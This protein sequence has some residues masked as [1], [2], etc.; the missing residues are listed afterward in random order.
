VLHLRTC[1]G[2]AGEYQLELDGDG[3]LRASL[4]GMTE[5]GSRIELAGGGGAAF[6]V[7]QPAGVLAAASQTASIA[8]GSVLNS[9]TFTPD[10]AAGGLI[11]VFGS[12]LAR[13]G[14]ET[15]VSVGGRTATVLTALPFQI[16]AQVPFDTPPGSHMLRIDAP[17]GSAGQPFEVRPAA[18]AVF[19]AGARAI[20]VNQSGKLNTPSSPARRGE[21][22]IVYAT[23]L[24]TVSGSGDVRP[25]VIP[26]AAF[27][28]SQEVRV[29]YAGLTPGFVGLYQINLV[30]HTTIPPGIDIPLTLRQGDI[31]SRPVEIS[32]F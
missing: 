28:R 2:S 32:V 4:T 7:T 27:L 16:N 20:V 26:V 6:R 22:V 17:W 10:T 15:R 21:S 24:G 23:G 29:D 31:E 19:R 11:S 30:I 14:R 5:G 18:P 3:A 1:D 9:A 25:A 8:A 12:G 13:T